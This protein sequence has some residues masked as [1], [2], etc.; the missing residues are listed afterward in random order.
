[1]LSHLAL[2]STAGVA[3]LVSL[4]VNNLQAASPLAAR[5]P[6]HPFALLIGLNVGPNLFVTGFLAWFLWL[7]AAHSPGAKPSIG[8]A[9]RLGV[10]AVPIS[11]AAA[12]GALVLSASR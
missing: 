2:W 6:P 3:A 10:V 5:V 8:T 4:L 9:S 11:M 1:M 7:R 12:L